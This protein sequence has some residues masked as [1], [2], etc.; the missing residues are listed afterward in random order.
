[1]KTML[2]I[3]ILFIFCAELLA[4][5]GYAATPF[6]QDRIQNQLS[7]LESNLGQ[8][9]HYRT[10]IPVNPENLTITTSNSTDILLAWEPVT[11]STT[12]APLIP[13]G[14]NIYYA[15]YPDQPWED[16]TFL[17]DTI[18]TSYVHAGVT[19]DLERMFYFVV[20]YKN[21]A[22]MP[23][24]FLLV[25]GGTFNNGISD[26]TISS[27]YLDKYELTQGGF[28]AVMGTNP[29]TGFG[30]GANYP[31]YFTSWFLAIE[32]CN[33]RSIAEDLTPCY[34]YGTYGTNP[35]DW[36][37]GWNNDYNNHTN[38]SCDWAAHGYRLPTEMEWMYA[39]KGGNQSLGC[40]YSGGSII[41]EV[42]WYYVNSG[43]A[44]HAVGTLAPNELGLYDM[45]GNVW[46]W[47][48]DIHGTYPLEPQTDPHGA[49][50]GSN[51]VI[52]GGSWGSVAAAC[53]VAY[54]NWYGA[55]TSYNSI[56][57]RCVRA[58]P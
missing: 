34:S 29:A 22:P 53:T 49:A 36:P 8:G 4:L 23:E 10:L 20:A 43:G 14:Y 26:V 54:R 1:M 58:V 48:W 9:S 16:F 44:T 45:S 42:A 25:E 31:V 19:S 56:G 47:V 15:S 7:K 46:E 30:V 21:E 55:T 28:Q 51:R 32:F 5:S 41:D 57:F 13:D 18:N 3:G 50:S 37:G 27:F 11:Q 35:A 2:P 39:A 40:V 38:V 33:W 52:R 24:T 17:D 6:S 12:G